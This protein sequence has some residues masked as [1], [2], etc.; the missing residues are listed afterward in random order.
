MKNISLLT[1]L[2]IILSVHLA[3][4]VVYSGAMDSRAGLQHIPGFIAQSLA[5]KAGGDPGEG[6]RLEWQ[7]DNASS[8]GFWTYTYRLIRGTA[9]SKGFAFFDIET[10]ADFT[11][12]NIV[13]RKVSWAT[14]RN[15]SDIPSGLASIT[16]SDPANFNTVHDFSNAAVTEANFSPTAL[17]KNDLSHY[18]GD[19]GIAAPG[20]PA[21]GASDTPSVG[22]VPHPFYGIRVTFPGSNADLA[23]EAVEWEFSITSDRAPMWGSFFGWGDKTQVSPFWY[24]NFYNVNID[25]PVRLT[26][27][28]ANNLF[29]APPYE[30]WILVPGP[31][32]V[33]QPSRLTVD[34]ATYQRSSGGGGN[35]TVLATALPTAVLTISGDGITPVIMTVDTGGAGSFSAQIPF[36]VLPS[37]IVISNS[38]DSVSVSPHPVIPVD[39]VII[40][41]ATY[42]PNTRIITIKAESSDGV[43]PLPTLTVPDFAR[44]NTLDATGTLVKTLSANPPKM[45]TVTSSKGGAGTAQVDIV[46]QSAIDPATSL[47]LFSNIQSPQITGTAVSFNAAASG[48]TGNYEYQFWLKDTSGAYTLV[49]PFSS[50]TTWNWSTFGLPA[51]AYTIAVQARSAGSSSA[52]GFDVENIMNFFIIAGVASTNPATA[53]NITE[54]PVSPQAIGTPI[55]FTGTASG[56]SGFYEYQFWLKDT[57]GTYTLVRPFSTNQDWVWDTTGALA[58]T[59][60]IAV[61]ARSVGTSPGGFNVE[62]TRSYVIQ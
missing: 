60:T 22:P 38:R 47:T 16:I 57:S 56:G 40:S 23:Y 12:A 10:A 3:H 51:G 41:Q 19:P 44:P 53:V 52:S 61:Q 11:A 55:T 54:N 27:P 33:A 36:T 37:P 25:N 8:P 59:Y 29:G 7:V 21:G 1:L 15:D 34:S 39:E 43:L 32:I 45:V 2:L 58:G 24:A 9:K 13:Q 18:S 35:L 17:S 6:L 42:D 48:G 4:A 50:S 28:T 30:G 5:F 31:Q 14:D 26:L 49:Q 46:T 20:V 62:A